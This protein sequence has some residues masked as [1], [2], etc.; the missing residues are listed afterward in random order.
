ML[1]KGAVERAL[2]ARRHRP[3]F[4]VD[5]A[6][7][8]DIEPEVS[9]LSD[10]YLYSVDDLQ[11]VIEENM[12][13]RQEAAEQAEEIIESHVDVLRKS[14]RAGGGETT[15]VT[16]GID[17]MGERYSGRIILMTSGGTV[18]AGEIFAISMRALPQVT[19]FGQ[20]TMGIL[21]DIL[22][23]TLPNGW[24]IGMS[25]E[26]YRTM[27]NELFESTGVP[28]D[29]AI[30]PVLSF[31]DDRLSGVDVGMEALLRWLDEEE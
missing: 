31:R 3:I 14:A 8:R 4:M 12:R 15:P 7:P 22:G 20:P 11:E 10:I 21:S 24:Q 17:P 29:V 30:D 27:D 25:N 23:R 9:E 2:K 19:I 26:I 18:S 1:G 5:I 13:S 6:V 28:V 16:V